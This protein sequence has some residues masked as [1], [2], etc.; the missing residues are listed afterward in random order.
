MAPILK[1]REKV[2]LA[3]TVGVIFFSILFN[4]LIVPVARRNDA[5]SGEIKVLRTRLA[6]Q[7]GL[8]ANKDE[9]SKKYQSLYAGLDLGSLQ[10]Q[11][12]VTMLS[13][14][15]RI[16]QVSGVKVVDVRPQGQQ[17]EKVMAVDF[18]AEGTMEGYFRFLYALDNSLALLRVR[19]VQLTARPGNAGVL[20]G[21]FTVAQGSP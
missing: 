4:F 18:K 19:R 2:I 17:G 20:E 9:I 10:A 12:L 7:K 8:L 13:E 21:L 6:R 15:E 3:L 5:L 16:A 11:T 14:I 1:R